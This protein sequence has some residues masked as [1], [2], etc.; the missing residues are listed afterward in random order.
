MTAII[1]AVDP[2]RTVGHFLPGLRYMNNNKWRMDPADVVLLG[3]SSSSGR[4]KHATKAG[5]ANSVTGAEFELTHNPTGIS[6]RGE[7]PRGE[8]SRREMQRLKE[9]LYSELFVQLEGSVAKHLR[10]AGR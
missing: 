10:I 8:Y 5:R 9:A 6:V 7:I 2:E 1:P 4:R 3:S